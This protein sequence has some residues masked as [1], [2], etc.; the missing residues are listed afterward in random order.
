M[1]KNFFLF[2]LFFLNFFWSSSQNLTVLDA[3]S[4]KAISFVN[5]FLY[6]NE[7][8]VKGGYCSEEGIVLVDKNISF[9]KVK[10]T[11]I[12]YENLEIFKKSIDNDTL[13]LIPAVY[14]LNEVVVNSNKK[15]ELVKIGYSESKRKTKFA[16]AKGKKMC[17]FISNPFN[18]IKIIHSF[19][20]KIHNANHSKVGFKLHL[21]EKDSLTNM[22]GKELLKEEIIVI[23]EGKNNKDV[24]HNVSEYNIDFPANGA[25]VG[26]E[27]VGVLNEENN[28]FRKNST[29]NGYIEINDESKEFTTF[30]QDVFSFYPWKNMERFKKINENI[31]PFKNCPTASFGVKLYKN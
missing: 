25:F 6:Q 5:Y 4:K 14:P 19:L 31:L 11:C 27:W 18:E 24:E 15:N 23:L 21:F 30:Q 29:E 12:G 16:A 9:D 22:P 13:L 7:E 20:F 1:I 2:I 8:L 3:K 17:V 10:L 28:N 26:V